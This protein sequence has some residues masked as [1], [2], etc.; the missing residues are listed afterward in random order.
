MASFVAFDLLHLNGEDLG[1]RPLQARR[2]ALMRLVA[3]L[4]GD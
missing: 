2:E 1:Q 4:R 3:N